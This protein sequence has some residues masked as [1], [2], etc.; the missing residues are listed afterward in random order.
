MSI[1]NCWKMR[2]Y[3]II[4]WPFR[5]VLFS[6]LLYTM[7]QSLDELTK[8]PKKSSKEVY[9]LLL[10]ELIDFFWMVVFSVVYDYYTLISL[11]FHLDLVIKIIG[12]L[13]NFFLLFIIYGILL[14][15]IFKYSKWAKMFIN[16]VNEPKYLQIYRCL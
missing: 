13:L 4:I 8:L 16:I 11:V 6:L 1:I 5:P 12:I 7:F 10:E 15:V 3:S 2:L 14:R 9:V